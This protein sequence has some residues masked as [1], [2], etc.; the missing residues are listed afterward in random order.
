MSI[1]YLI[2]PFTG[3]NV[4][5]IVSSETGQTDAT[6]FLIVRIPDG[7][8]IQGNP[9]N[10]TDLLTAKYSGLLASYAGFTNI[11]ADPCLDQTNIDLVNSY[12]LMVGAGYVNH[13]IAPGVFFGRQYMSVPM[14]LGSTPTQCIIAWEEFSFLNS[15]NKDQRFQRTYVEES[16]T[17]CSC[18]V[19][20][21]GGT[22]FNTVQNGAVFTIP[23]SD[24][25]SSFIITLTK[26]SGAPLQ[27]IYLGSWALIF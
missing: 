2:D 20:F 8:K 27:R 25:G 14:T 1:Y 22:T 11:I 4:V 7:V 5:D 21:N 10:L 12:D 6:G 23:G 3:G 26:S 18:D 15:D 19:S 24:Q 16:G 9:T 13:C 17:I